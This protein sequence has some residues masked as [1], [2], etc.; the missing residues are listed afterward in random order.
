MDIL[1]TNRTLVQSLEKVH[2]I[3]ISCGAAFTACITDAGDV[4]TF[5][6]N[7]NGQ[8]GLGHK[9]NQAS[10]QLVAPFSVRIIS[11]S[12]GNYHTVCIDEEKHLWGFGKN[13]HGQLGGYQ[14]SDQLTSV[15]SI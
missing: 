11:V 4:W 12:C 8:L 15:R 6:D 2:V 7:K 9:E 14:C 5:G 3:Q 1:E 10:P 13:E